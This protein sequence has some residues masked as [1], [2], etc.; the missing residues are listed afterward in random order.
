M[1]WPS[2]GAL[3]E[4]PG[5]IG[6]EGRGGASPNSG[7]LRRGGET[8]CDRHPGAFTEERGVWGGVFL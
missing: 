2:A 3:D 8:S 5:R 1:G 4:D 6:A 7:V